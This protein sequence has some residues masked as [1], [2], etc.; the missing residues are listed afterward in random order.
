MGRLIG[1]AR[2]RKILGA[3]CLLLTIAIGWLALRSPASPIGAATVNKIRPGMPRAEVENLLGGPPGDYCHRRT[4]YDAVGVL[5]PEGQLVAAEYSLE[6]TEEWHGDRMLI[7]VK[8]GPTDK[9]ESAFGLRRAPPSWYRAW[10]RWLPF[11]N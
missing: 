1:T 2:F 7:A 8:F 5:V 4:I 11:L 10:Q 6:G 9:V 3:T